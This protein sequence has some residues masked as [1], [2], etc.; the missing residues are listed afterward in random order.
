MLNSQIAMR[1]RLYSLTFISILAWM[2]S[3]FLVLR[4]SDESPAIFSPQTG[5]V[6]R[7]IT[8]VEVYTDLSGFEHAELSFGYTGDPTQTWFLIAA[9][10]QPVLDGVLAQWDTTTITDGIYTLR[11]V[12]FRRSQEPSEYRVDGLRVRNY[13]AIETPTPE[14][15]APDGLTAKIVLP[16]ATLTPTLALPTRTAFP[17]NPAVLTLPQVGLSMGWGILGLVAVLVFAAGYLSV[18]RAIIDREP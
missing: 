7:G 9:S 5:Q 4:Q 12:V 1:T 3:G 2:A 18:R 17:T 16:T 6:L 14:A 10:N 11:L 15:S 13:T 8:P